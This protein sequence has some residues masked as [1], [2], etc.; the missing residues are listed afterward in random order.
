M[1]AH[2]YMYARIKFPYWTSLRVQVRMQ[3]D[4]VEGKLH[5]C[6]TFVHFHSVDAPVRP[7]LHL[8]KRIREQQSTILAQF[9]SDAR[10]NT[11]RTNSPTLHKATVLK[12]IMQFFDIEF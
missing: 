4:E 8:R 3:G 11:L 9:E 7:Y 5:S 1:F 10:R 12:E 2:V 6:T